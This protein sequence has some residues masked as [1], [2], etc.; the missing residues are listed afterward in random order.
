MKAKFPI[1]GAAELLRILDP[2]VPDSFIN[3]QFSPRS[4]RGPRRYFSA[5]QLWRTHLLAVLTPVHSLNQL[6][7][8]LPEQRA[9]RT[10]A[11][12]SHRQRVP[13]VRMLNEFRARAG[14]AGLRKINDQLRG[15]FIKQASG[16]AHAV[17]LMDATDL[18]AACDGFKKKRR[19]PT[20]PS[21]QPWGCA[22]TNRGRVAGT[23]GTK[24]IHC[25]CGGGSILR[26]CGWCR[27]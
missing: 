4:A 25:G 5:A 2:F 14:V 12:L 10:F 15:Q 17:A 24:N 18:E 1:T 19:K 21:V 22:R 3:Q 16:W 6:I 7:A 13:D 27:W 20:R 8:L 23:W 26:R 9:W 11:R